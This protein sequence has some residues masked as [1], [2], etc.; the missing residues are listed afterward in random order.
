MAKH[1]TEAR[2]YPTEVELEEVEELVE[3]EPEVPDHQESGE[4]LEVDEEL[5]V[6]T[7]RE[8]HGGNDYVLPDRNRD[9]WKRFG[10]NTEAGRLLRRLYNTKGQADG[11]ARVSYPRLP[12]PARSWEAQPP[13]RK[14]CPQRALIKVPRL[15]EATPDRDD[16]R[17]W[18]APIP[19]RKPASQIFAELECHTP[20]R[21]PDLKPGRDL[22]RE[23]ADLQDCFHFC[24]GRALPRGAMGHVPQGQLP[25]TVASHRAVRNTRDPTTGM[26][27]E[28]Q[29]IFQDLMQSVKEKQERLA[30]IQAE[31]ATDTKPSKAKTARN[32]EAL[33]LRNGIERCLQDINTLL[34][35]TE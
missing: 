26:T 8:D 1:L 30:T 28:Q 7:H 11:A 35:I 10:H 20:Q 27:G 5:D 34:S 29:E 32:K 17:N 15:R 12:S 13:P 4:A 33:E 2:T 19:C 23:K 3:T 18:R 9:V 16:P 24:G 31:E 14:A 25:K 21:P 6:N 22:S